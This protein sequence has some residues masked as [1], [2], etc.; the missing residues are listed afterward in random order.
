MTNDEAQKRLLTA[1]EHINLLN[2]YSSLLLSAFMDLS[3]TPDLPR[4]A[5]QK[6]TQWIKVLQVASGRIEELVLTP[7]ELP[8]GS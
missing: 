4:E 7:E 2:D 8:H 1:Y 6:S 5:I 3:Q